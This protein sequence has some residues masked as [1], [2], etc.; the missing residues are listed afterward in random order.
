MEFNIC[1]LHKLNL[2]LSTGPDEAAVWSGSALFD[3]ICLSQ[4]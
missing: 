3:Q 1:L 4:Y 2:E